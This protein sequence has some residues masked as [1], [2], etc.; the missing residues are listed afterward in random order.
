ML[1]FTY[2]L[3]SKQFSRGSSGK[4]ITIYP[5]DEKIFEKVLE[6]LHDKLYFEEGPY[7]LSD[8]RYKEEGILYYRYGGLKKH[9]MID[10][11]GRKIPIIFAPN[12][13]KIEDKRLPYYRTPYWVKD[14]IFSKKKKV[15][16]ELI[17]K[18][19]TE[20]LRQYIFQT[21]GECIR[22]LTN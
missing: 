21:V 22:L 5:R 19:D 14:L 10:I 13:Q 8:R 12:G 16:K 20:Y 6:D 18:K 11:T 3:N 1:T 7:I 2:V 17:L 9:F 15:L 4:F